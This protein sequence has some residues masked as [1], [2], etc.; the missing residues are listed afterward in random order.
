[1]KIYEPCDTT[2]DY[3]IEQEC[4]RQWE[5]ENAPKSV[6]LDKVDKDKVLNAWAWMNTTRAILF[7][8]LIER[9]NTAAEMIKDTPEYDRIMSMIDQLEDIKAEYIRVEDTLD[10]NWRGR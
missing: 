10:Q 8:D 1:M 4:Y 5:E 6:P 2:L 7:D 9:M 3:Q